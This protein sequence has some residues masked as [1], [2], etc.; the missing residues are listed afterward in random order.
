MTLDD[1]RTVQ[2]R[3]INGRPFKGMGE[4]SEEAVEPDGAAAGEDYAF[5]H[6]YFLWQGYEVQ[7]GWG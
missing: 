6:P 2:P 7:L 1:N 4:M 3:V 5:M